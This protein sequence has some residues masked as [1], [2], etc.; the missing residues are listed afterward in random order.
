MVNN[1]EDRN[2][3]ASKL[4]REISEETRDV[5]DW[6]R[7]EGKYAY[8]KERRKECEVNG[9]KEPVQ[10]MRYPSPFFDDHPFR[11]VIPMYCKYCEI[12]Y[13]REPTS[14]ETKRYYQRRRNFLKLMSEPMTI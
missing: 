7:G 11:A 5:S 9:H 6:I 13:G 12:F 4:S 8:L 10:S 2:I 14:E 1:L 3:V